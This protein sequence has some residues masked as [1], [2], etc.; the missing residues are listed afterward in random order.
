VLDRFTAVYGAPSFENCATPVGSTGHAC[1][2]RWLSNDGVALDVF[3]QTD[4]TNRRPLTQIAVVA[5]DIQRATRR[6]GS[7]VPPAVATPAAPAAADPV[8]KAWPT[9]KPTD[10]T[11]RG[12]RPIDQFFSNL[13]HR[14]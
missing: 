5:T 6:F 8:V 9:A 12:E 14:R 2:L 3:S 13:K 11:P 4:T 1:H 7:Q 10:S